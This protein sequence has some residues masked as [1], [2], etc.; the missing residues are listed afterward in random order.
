[1]TLG[2]ERS[3]AMSD[4]G[5]RLTRVA[6]DVDHVG[7][8]GAQPA[9]F[10]NNFRQGKARSVVDFGEDFDVIAAIIV[11]AGRLAEEFVE[12]AEVAGSALDAGRSQRLNRREIA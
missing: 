11:A 6:A 9:S 7:P 5:P 8:A 1:M 2:F 12:I 3:H 10:R 4:T